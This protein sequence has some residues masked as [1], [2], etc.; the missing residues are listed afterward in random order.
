MKC[1]E[2]TL[3]HWKIKSQV[4]RKCSSGN[5]FVGSKILTFIILKYPS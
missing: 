2:C 1:Y 3:N 5:E 4:Q